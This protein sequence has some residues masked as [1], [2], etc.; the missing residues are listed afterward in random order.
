M[1]PSTCRSSLRV[2]IGS[3]SIIAHTEPFSPAA[4][5][6]VCTSPIGTSLL[7]T[8]FF[9][10]TDLISTTRSL[11]I[12]FTRLLWSLNLSHAKDL[13]GADIPVDVNAYSEGFSSHPLHF[14]CKIEKRGDWVTSAVEAAMDSAGIDKPE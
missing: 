6:L 8:I 4:S 1:T 3:W 9:A 2:K 14:E 7:P 11:F 12:V 10:C 13:S 5:A